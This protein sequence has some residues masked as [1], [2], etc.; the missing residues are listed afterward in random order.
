MDNGQ[1]ERDQRTNQR[2]NSN[3]NDNHGRRVSFAIHPFFGRKGAFVVSSSETF[4]GYLNRITFIWVSCESCV[5]K[6]NFREKMMSYDFDEILYCSTHYWCYLHP[7]E[8]VN[9][10][11]TSENLKLSRRVK[12]KSIDWRS[13]DHKRRVENFRRSHD[14]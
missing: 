8:E 9:T 7:F 5:I 12:K 6:P 2:D 4:H 10:S 14:I 11:N 1:Y 13:L 3:G